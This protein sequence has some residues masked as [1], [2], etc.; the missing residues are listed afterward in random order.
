M[1]RASVLSSLSF[2]FFES[3]FLQIAMPGVNRRHTEEFARNN[4]SDSKSHLFVQW[5]QTIQEMRVEVGVRMALVE[6]KL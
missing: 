4:Q 1:Q 5:R 2:L 6:F 3:K